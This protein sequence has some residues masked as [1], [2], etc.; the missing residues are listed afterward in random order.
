[1][2][3]V[4]NINCS[5]LAGSTLMIIPYAIGSLVMASKPTRGRDPKWPFAEFPS[6]MV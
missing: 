1:M 5:C 2:N 4:Y 6:T 3:R